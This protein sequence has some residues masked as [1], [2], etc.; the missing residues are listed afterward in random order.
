MTRPLIEVFDPSLH[1]PSLLKDFRNQ[2]SSLAQYLQRFAR[3]NVERH[4]LNQTFLTLDRSGASPRVAGF[5]T[6]AYCSVEAEPAKGALDSLRKLPGYPIPAILLAQL[7]VDERVQGQGLG[8][9][10]VEEAL[11][12]VLRV[13]E[14]GEIPLRLFVTDALNEAAVGFYETCGMTRITDG[15][16]A[17][18]VLDLKALEFAPDHQAAKKISKRK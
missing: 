15:Y 3:K 9:Y 4:R 14:V 1:P 12:R 11:L 17:R 10:L 5:F 6:L 13:I 2:E 18:M 7:A 8:T 16:P